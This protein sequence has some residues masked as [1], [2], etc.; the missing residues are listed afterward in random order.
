MRSLKNIWHAA[1][2]LASLHD[3]PCIE[4]LVDSSCP[5]NFDFDAA[6][7]DE[8]SH[9]KQRAELCLELQGVVEAMQMETAWDIKP[10]LDGKSVMQV[11]G[12]KQGGPQLGV[13]MDAQLRWQLQHPNSTRE[14]CLAW[15]HTQGQKVN[16]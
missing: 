16:A 13:V 11:L 14:E 6:P 8:V 15:V 1:L 2:V 9:A 12:M 10:L 4:T 7:A 3:L 5:V